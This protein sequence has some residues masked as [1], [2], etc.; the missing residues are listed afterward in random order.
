M[1][2]DFEIRSKFPGI[3]LLEHYQGWKCYI[4]S[5]VDNARNITHSSCNTKTT[6]CMEAV[7]RETSTAIEPGQSILWRACMQQNNKPIRNLLYS[8]LEPAN[9]RRRPRTPPSGW[10]WVRRR[11]HLMLVRYD[12]ALGAISW[13]RAALP[14]FKRGPL[15]LKKWKGKSP[16]NA[17][18][19][20]CTP[21]TI[22]ESRYPV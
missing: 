10:S 1:V 13:R 9:R 16:G 6:G 5:V 17:L 20:P 7:W 19:V 3:P 22:R 14:N 8:P 11:S 4:E 2:L 15:P 18:L 12:N 21:L